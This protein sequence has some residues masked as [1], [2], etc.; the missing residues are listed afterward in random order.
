MA[1]GTL[2]N[3]YQQ[4]KA[5]T[6]KLV[7]W[8]ANAARSCK[9]VSTI[10]PS[11]RA[12]RNAAKQ[13]KRKQKQ[14]AP[15]DTKVTLTT[16][17]L[18]SLT[19]IVVEAAVSIPADIIRT[20]QAVI[21]SRQTHADWYSS[22]T[23]PTNTAQAEQNH[24][25]QYFIDVLKKVLRL[26]E[27]SP[28]APIAKKASTSGAANV[29][30]D[31][32]K[33]KDTVANV[34]TY[35]H[36]EEPLETALGS[37]PASSQATASKVHFELE[38]PAGDSAFAVW[39]LLYDL[40]ELRQEIRRLWVDYRD[41]KISFSAVAELTADAVVMAQYAEY[42]FVE[43]YPKLWAYAHI[44]NLLDLDICAIGPNVWV[45]PI[46][47]DGGGDVQIG[48]VCGEAVVDLL[49]P[50]A[51]ILLTEFV[52]ELAQNIGRKPRETGTNQPHYLEIHSFGQALKDLLPHLDEQKLGK[53]HKPQKD[54][55]FQACII[56]AENP[57]RLP[58]TWMIM[59]C[60]IHMDLHDVMGSN[61]SSGIRDF[62]DRYAADLTS[63]RNFS[64][65]TELPSGVTSHEKFS[66]ECKKIIQLLEKFSKDP[67]H[68]GD[69][70]TS[71]VYERGDTPHPPPFALYH[72][73]PITP[74]T[75]VNSSATRVH[76]FGIDVCNYYCVV[77]AVAYLYKFAL[78][79]GTIKSRWEDMEFIIGAQSRER[80]F[81]LE[82]DAGT[83]SAAGCF[84]LAL[85]VKLKNYAKGRR[86]QLP[87]L[88]YIERNS[89]KVVDYPL[90]NGTTSYKFAGP[91][92]MGK[93]VASKIDTAIRSSKELENV[94]LKDKPVDDIYQRYK[95]N[96]KMTLVQLLLALKKV[97]TLHET[98]MKFD[99]LSFSLTCE[100]MLQSVVTSASPALTGLQ[101]RQPFNFGVAYEIVFAVLSDTADQGKRSKMPKQDVL[102]QIGQSMEDWITVKGSR[103]SNLTKAQTSGH[104]TAI[105][106]NNSAKP[107]KEQGGVHESK[108]DMDEDLIEYL[109]HMGLLAHVPAR[110]EGNFVGTKELSDAQILVH[111]TLQKAKIDSTG[112]DT[113]DVIEASKRYSELQW[114]H[115]S[116]AEREVMKKRRDR[117]MRKFGEVTESM[118]SQSGSSE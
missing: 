64:T 51:V 70:E 67:F 115:M 27:T 85:G 79:A 109:R 91:A 21:S 103:F 75:M 41:G 23:S 46:S 106:T 81:V 71:K 89:K 29:S 32:S 78:K 57:G 9:D 31:K 5:G 45:H 92:V 38:K 35:L 19:Q 73:F 3:S 17:Q 60:Q 49:C 50:R 118:R 58:N 62:Q 30:K 112:F 104:S 33:A 86:A 110:T 74:G 83:A 36:V 108:D 65:T 93:G 114:E 14:T 90:L 84:G 100:K 82:S 13:A 59:A 20:T 4:Y 26:L 97:F 88:E 111:E 18:L 87:T 66:G 63:L 52:S 105:S 43:Q 2:I 47:S 107:S 99:W 95:N 56:L 24:T 54:P 69:T 22:C 117:V 42:V 37:P 8:L 40:R 1:D 48:R 6:T 53:L 72:V 76:S 16:S 96:G 68:D 61:F 11:L 34:F 116:A 39:C 101:L 10:V 25:H 15:L 44:L 113:Q 80:P 7:D 102:Q 98:D 94:D 55:F 12:A 77:L 28:G